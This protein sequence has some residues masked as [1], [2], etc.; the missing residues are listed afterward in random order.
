[1][2]EKR[3]N[4]VEPENGPQLA[5]IKETLDSLHSF[6][7]KQNQSRTFKIEEHIP[8]DLERQMES[9]DKIS[10]QDK[11]SES[12]DSSFTW[13]YNTAVGQQK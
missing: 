6:L 2:N 5:K 11:D 10:L 7:S 9:I 4:E 8:S 3:G 12:N 1:M 13:K